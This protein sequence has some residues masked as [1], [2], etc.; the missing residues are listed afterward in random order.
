[1]VGSVD[2]LLRETHSDDDSIEI[3]TTT[4]LEL[5]NLSVHPS[6]RR[7]GIASRL[8]DAVQ[9]YAQSLELSTTV[10]YLNVAFDNNGARALYERKGFKVDHLDFE[11]MFW[12]S[13]SLSRPIDT[14]QGSNKAT[15]GGQSMH[16][17]T[18]SG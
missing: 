11:R 3:T 2:V 15:R 1:M 9:K 16:P 12:I 7:M 5:R 13:E 10:V 14:T 4:T 8:V 6:L 17:E 18:F